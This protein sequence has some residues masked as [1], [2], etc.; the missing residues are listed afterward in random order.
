MCGAVGV[1][2]GEF[3]QTVCGGPQRIVVGPLGQVDR[4]RPAVDKAIAFRTLLGAGESAVAGE[5]DLQI[6][7]GHDRR[8]RSELNRGHTTVWQ[9]R[10]GLPT[11]ALPAVRW[12]I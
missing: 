10:P 4:H 7:D 3:A 6:A 12:A 11:I 8:Y 2:I 5:G 9:L 1:D